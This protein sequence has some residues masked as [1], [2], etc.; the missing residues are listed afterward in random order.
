M[1]P[2]ITP[3]AA[4]LAGKINI[5]IHCRVIHIWTIPDFS[6]PNEDGSMH[7]LL[8]DEKVY[9]LASIQHK[10]FT[11]YDVALHFIEYVF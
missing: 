11:S 8:L 10:A 6:N 7:M 4:I 1:A 9:Y 2:V 3:I 5:K